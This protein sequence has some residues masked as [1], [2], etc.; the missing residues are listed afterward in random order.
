MIRGIYGWAVIKG[1]FRI[2][3]TEFD[4]LDAGRIQ[5]LTSISYDKRHG[6]KSREFTGGT[7]PAGW[8]GKDGKLWFPTIQG[9]ASVDPSVLNNDPI[10]SP[11]V[12]EQIS[13]EHEPLSAE[14]QIGPLLVL[15]P[16]TGRIEFS[17]AAL[18]FVAPEKVNYR[19][20]LE[21]YESSW[22][23]VV[24]YRHASYTHL[25]PG[26]YTFHVIAQNSE[27]VWNE[28]GAS[29]MFELRPYF[30][31]SPYFWVIFI[32]CTGL[33]GI[34]GYRWRI[35]QLTSQ[36]KRLEVAVMERTTDLTKAKEHIELQTE[37]LR[38][39]LQEKEVLLREV[40]HR[41]KNNLQVI[42]SLLN[43]QSFRVKDPDTKA[44]FKECHDRINSMTM[45]HER[46][47]Q[48]DDLTEIDLA[49]YLENISVELAR[50]YNADRRKIKVNVNVADVRLGLDQAIP[51]GLIVNE[52][53]SNALK[54]AFTNQH[55]GEIDIIFGKSDSTYTLSVCDNG[56]GLPDSFD[57]NKTP[58]LGMKLV[59]ALTQKLK[60][61]LTVQSNNFTHIQIAFPQL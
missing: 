38:N 41:V 1:V 60:G 22:S 23:D 32:L 37:E 13:V 16:G 42:T 39:S 59:H 45:I 48:S 2:S 51:S 19:Y 43:L 34:T 12:I 58:S 44:L 54:H 26:T 11:V 25:D 4:A 9:I 21:G 47:Y 49:N 6:L 17:Y 57:V 56:I 29:F 36:Q 3:K 52:L 27:G 50:S 46:L 10:S 61:T 24:S 53:V 55:S 18:T 31:Q 33:L 20:R 40:H 7:Q 5:R 35:N 15:P 30:Y 8:K 14:E 28:Q